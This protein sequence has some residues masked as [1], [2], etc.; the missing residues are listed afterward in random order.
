MAMVIA[1]QCHEDAVVKLLG[2]LLTG[3]PTKGEDLCLHCSDV[4]P[5]ARQVKTEGVTCTIQFCFTESCPDTRARLL[6]LVGNRQARELY[7]ASVGGL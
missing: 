6:K 4:H 5:K 7:K 1:M 2:Q 3:L